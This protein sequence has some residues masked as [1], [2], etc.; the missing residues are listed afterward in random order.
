MS[1]FNESAR[2]PATKTVN[3]AGGEAFTQSAKLELAS[4][5][6][7][8]FVKD[9][10]YRSADD[11]LKRVN[12]LLGNV[13]PYFAAQA[14]IYTRNEFG[15]RSISHVVA[16]ELAHRVK[17]EEWTKRFFD[18]VV[19][20]PDDMA[21]ILG[22]HA[23]LQG[24]LKPVPNSMKKGFGSAFQRF[25]AY[26]LGKYKMEGKDISLVDIV[27]LVRPIS[28]EAIT[29]LMKGELKSETY[30]TGLTQAGQ[31][32]E[33]VE[34]KEV[35]K[36]DVWKKFLDNP[37][38]EYFALLRNLR[39]IEEQ[40]P[41][42][43]DQALTIL[44][45]PRRIK[46][47]KVMPFRFITAIEQF[48]PA[49][50]VYGMFSS[51][52][53]F[54][55]ST[56]DANTRKIV[57]ALSKAMDVSVDNVPQLPGNTLVCIDQSGSMGGRVSQIAGLFAAALVKGLNAD[58]VGFEFNAKYINYDPTL[59]I[60]ALAKKFA[61]S[62][63]GTNF[64]SIFETITKEGRVYDRI[65][66]LSDMQGWVGYNSPQADYV[67]YKRE[68]GVKTK[69]YSFD[70]AGNGSL[71]FPEQDVYALAGFSEKAFDVMA[72]LDEDPQALVHRIERVE[73]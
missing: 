22:Y 28:N 48:Q 9:Q 13:D 36:K 20:R 1:R 37:K 34:E 53:K 10:F 40:A 67:K 57:Q 29:A 64:H 55:K 12:E 41:E 33:T 69:V 47:S 49:A 70:L 58:L 59:S 18:K 35:L 65:I 11:S 6:L 43:L 51:T 66:I 62:Y 60:S 50:P 2:K 56:G 26:Q 31:K 16:G 4:L 39:N 25:D 21:E 5:M 15:M 73:I 32:A 8:S 24:S 30:Q 46:G 23:K 44:V 7:T 42:Y 19:R 61:Y 3:L 72:M 45:D 27:N 68:F 63:G 17:G 14:A 52:K 54:D 71:Q 38:V